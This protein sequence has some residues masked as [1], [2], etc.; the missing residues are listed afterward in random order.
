M[1]DYEIHE[2]PN[3]IRLI[4]KHVPYTKISHCGFMLDA[5]SRDEAEDQWGIAH[6][7]EHMAFKGTGKRKAFHIL[8]SIDA[9]GGELN[10]YTTKE[11]VCFHASVLDKYFPKAFELLAD[12]TFDSIFPEKQIENEKRVILEEMA[13]YT[14]VPEDAIQDDFDEVVFGGH[15]LGKNIL[16]SRES[17]M[18]FGR[19]DFR[20]FIDGNMDTGRIVFSYIGSEP[21][22]K[23]FKLGEKLLSGIV[24]KTI[25][26]ERK[27]FETY[28]AND[29]VVSK[30][31][32]Q[33]HVAIGNVGYGIGHPDRLNLFM[34]SN[35]LGGPALNSRLNLALREKY[36]YVYS[37]EAGSSAMTDTGLF[38]IFYA[39]EPKY[40]KKTQALVYKE[41]KKLREVPLGAVQLRRAKEQLLGQMAM[42]EENNQS[43]MLVMAKSLLDLGRIESFEAVTRRVQEVTSEDLQR[44]ALEVFDEK[45][46][47]TL[48][49]VPE[50]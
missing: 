31:C 11:K 29:K 34:L 25:E 16:G 6:F 48:T 10:A 45:K 44:V 13:M 46:L 36:G 7:W 22:S 49:F 21:A 28:V 35:I 43:L 14:E 15:T 12:I 33:V 20:R 3:G 19:D 8:N 37:I 41:L 42:S 39:T 2:L 27:P 4:H 18:A 50:D 32:S 1:R 30:D 17:V 9:V 40:S 23:V 5:G 26:R 24:K 47:S 38:S